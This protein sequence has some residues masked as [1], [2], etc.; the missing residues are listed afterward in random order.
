LGN[1]IICPLNPDYSEFINA[2]GAHD[3]PLWRPDWDMV[4]TEI[5]ENSNDFQKTFCPMDIL[6]GLKEGGDET[7]SCHSGYV[8]SLYETEDVNKAS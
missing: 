1:A 3:P 6:M 2:P 4:W 5:S 8:T 7:T